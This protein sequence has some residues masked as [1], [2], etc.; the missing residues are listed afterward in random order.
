MITRLCADRVV[1]NPL[2]FNTNNHYND[3][4]IDQPENYKEVIARGHT[5]HWVDK[6]HTEYHTITLDKHDLR[7][8]IE[9]YYKVGC[10]TRKY[11]RLYDEEIQDTLSKYELPEGKWFVRT[12]SVSL[13]EGMHGIGP[14]SDLR[15]IIESMVSSRLGHNCFEK[16]Y[17]SCTIYLFPWIE[18]SQFKE[19]R[20][21]VCEDKITAIS[22]QHPYQVNEWLNTLGDHEILDIIEKI[23]RYFQINIKTKLE[24]IGGNYTMD[25]ALVGPDNTPYFIEPNSFGKYYAAGSALFSWVYDHDTLHDSEVI[26]LRYCNKI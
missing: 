9:C 12:D 19:F 3:E 7:W 10:I 8:M 18:L 23:N 14:Y 20:V 21:F 5:K 24:Y 4:G 26:E 25:L 2:L 22:D 17:T 1:S 11:S 15:S 13:K 16:E 6:F